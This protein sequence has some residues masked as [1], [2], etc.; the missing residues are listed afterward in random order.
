[1]KNLAVD[2]SY[3]ALSNQYKN[4]LKEWQIKTGDDDFTVPDPQYVDPSLQVQK[5]V[6]PQFRFSLK[7]PGADQVFY[8]E[9]KDIRRVGI[10]DLEGR[11]V[12]DVRTASDNAS[13]MGRHSLKEGVYIAR[14]A[15]KNKEYYRN[16]F[17]KHR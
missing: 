14:F 11:L 6:R 10:Y 5:G 16:V 2:G 7:M 3:A 8:L 17:V 4:M 13:L 1:M 9:E 12:H 15:G